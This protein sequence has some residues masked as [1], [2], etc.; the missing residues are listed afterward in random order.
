[1]IAFSRKIIGHFK[2]SIVAMSGLCEKQAQ[3]N[4]PDQQLV[5]GCFNTMELYLLHARASC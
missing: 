5:P 2:H 4:V 3:L 1:M